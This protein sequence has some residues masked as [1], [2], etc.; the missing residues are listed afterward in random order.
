MD[1]FQGSSPRK[2]IS[3]CLENPVE[4]THSTP[5]PTF[6]QVSTAID[7]EGPRPENQPDQRASSKDDSDEDVNAYAASIVCQKEKSPYFGTD[8]AGNTV[9]QVQQTLESAAT[10]SD[11]T[12]QVR[13]STPSTSRSE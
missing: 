9:V 3:F 2:F 5:N 6:V 10:G 12:T 1:S 8:Q 4:E 11:I 13:T 7:G